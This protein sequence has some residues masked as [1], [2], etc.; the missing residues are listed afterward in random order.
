MV[1][2]VIRP[3]DRAGR[4]LSRGQGMGRGLSVIRTRTGMGPESEV[5]AETGSMSEL[6]SGQG[7][8]RGLGWGQGWDCPWPVPW[9][10]QGRDP[11]LGRGQGRVYL[12][13][14]W[15]SGLGRGRA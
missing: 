1:K 8:G 4:G 13:C 6:G 11:S 12:G 15:G 14:E 10:G 3:G 2:Q 7:L 5:S 9:S